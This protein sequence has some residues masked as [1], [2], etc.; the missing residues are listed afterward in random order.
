[1]QVHSEHSR[2]S[3]SNAST[4][5]KQS[6]QIIDVY[7]HISVC[8]Q[9][10]AAHLNFSLTCLN[11]EAVPMILIC[12]DT[13][14]HVLRKAEFRFGKSSLFQ[15]LYSKPKSSAVGLSVIREHKTFR[16]LDL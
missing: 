10:Q 5:A 6:D 1:M 16:N 2:D 13:P 8:V 9:K 4:F 12:A 11:K 14:A 7:S 3:V 15:S